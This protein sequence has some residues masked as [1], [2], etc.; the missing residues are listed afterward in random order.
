MEKD[1]EQTKQAVTHCDA[2]DL[3]LGLDRGLRIGLGYSGIRGMQKSGRAGNNAWR[4]INDVGF[5]LGAMC[6]AIEFLYFGQ[7]TRCDVMSTRVGKD[8]DAE[9]FE[10]S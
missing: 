3:G 1:P 6:S 9:G 10:V 8:K 5:A 4:L 2:G 7:S